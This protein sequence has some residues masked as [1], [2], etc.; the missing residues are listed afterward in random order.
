MSQKSHKIDRFIFTRV[1]NYTNN[2]FF[3]FNDNKILYN[4]T[5]YQ[6]INSEWS[7]VDA[8]NKY[9]YIGFVPYEVLSDQVSQNESLRK[10]IEKLMKN[11]QVK[12]YRS[13]KNFDQQ[14][15]R[16]KTVMKCIGY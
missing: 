5:T 13:A 8:E 7:E 9:E 15:K 6:R 11:K 12:K 14:A 16:I 1:A 2:T 3:V 4:N 10:E